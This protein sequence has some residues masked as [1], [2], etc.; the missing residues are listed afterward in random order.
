MHT[1]Q[2]GNLFRGAVLRSDGYYRGRY[3]VKN[4]FHVLIITKNIGMHMWKTLEKGRG[5]AENYNLKLWQ[6]MIQD[7]SKRLLTYKKRSCP[8]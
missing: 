7:Y 4:T 3:E 5:R 1:I 2:S 6:E 8:E